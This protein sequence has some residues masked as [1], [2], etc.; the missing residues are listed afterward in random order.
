[1]RKRKLPG[2]PKM[3]PLRYHHEIKCVMQQF[4]DDILRDIL[5]D[6]RLD[7]EAFVKVTEFSSFGS[8]PTG[9]LG[10][11]KDIKGNEVS[12]RLYEIRTKG[13]TDA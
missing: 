5:K 4:Q 6:A 9:T 2:V 13:E 8:C 1:M 12:K 3:V 11:I 10:I 7:D